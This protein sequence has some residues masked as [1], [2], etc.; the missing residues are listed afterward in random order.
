V[1]CRARRA[2]LAGAEEALEEAT[3]ALEEARVALG[4]VAEELHAAREA[5]GPALAESV[6]ERLASLAMEG[7]TFE[8]ALHEREPG[9]TG[10]DVVEFLIAANPGVPAGP[11][12]DIASGGEVSRVMLALMGVANESGGATLVFDE[13]DAGIGGVTAR[14]VGEQ[15]RALGE[16]RQVICITHLPQVASLAARHFSIAKDVDAEPARTTVTELV[17]DAIV[18]ELVRMLGAD[19]EDKAAR[20]HAVELLKA[21]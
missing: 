20:R 15:L 6:R 11:L 16:G 5:A 12:R 14:A 2:E 10:A 1:R 8:V 17:P 3:A 9:A 4:K 13:V 18:G 21:A 19:A 7:A